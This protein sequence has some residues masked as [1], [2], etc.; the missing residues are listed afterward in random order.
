MNTLLISIPL[1]GFFWT[2]FLF[3]FCFGGMYVVELIKLGWLYQYNPPPDTN[4]EEVK[5]E[6]EKAPASNAQEPIYYIVEKKKRRPKT[7]YGDPK[8]FRF[9]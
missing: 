2:I 5:T 6:K 8:P 1:Q 3:L 9:K 7:D 4:K